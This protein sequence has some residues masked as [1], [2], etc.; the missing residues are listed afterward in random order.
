MVW[1][2]TDGDNGGVSGNASAGTVDGSAATTDLHQA[3]ASMAKRMDAMAGIIDKRFEGLA[4]KVRETTTHKTDAPADAIPVTQADLSAAYELGIV[5]AVLPDAAREHISTMSGSMSE[6][7][8]AARLIKQFATPSTSV[9]T[10]PAGA[11][12]PGLAATAA[13][14][15]APTVPTTQAEWI[16]LTTASKKDAGAKAR[17]QQLID[18]DSFEPSQLPV[19]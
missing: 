11:I 8:A 14:R 19:R 10:S 5:T 6:R 16:A 1:I 7:L 9:G 13:P 2:M 12:P 4:N 18:D 15:T 3:I 17:W